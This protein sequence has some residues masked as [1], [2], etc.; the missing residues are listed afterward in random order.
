VGG[1]VKINR[2]FGMG[3]WAMPTLR[4]PA[5]KRRKVATQCPQD[6][7]EQLSKANAKRQRKALKMA[8]QKEGDE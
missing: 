1:V 8:Q 5:R 7:A 3:D 4:T 6:A 2:W